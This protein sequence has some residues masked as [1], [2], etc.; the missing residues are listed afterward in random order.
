MAGLNSS[1]PDHRCPPLPTRAADEHAKHT[2]KE[3]RQEVVLYDHPALNPIYRY[4]LQPGEVA[5]SVKPVHLA[6][7][8]T[9]TSPGAVP[10]GSVQPLVAV[11]TGQGFG[12]DSKCMGRVLLFRVQKQ[13]EPAEGESQWGV[14]LVAAKDCASAGG[15]PGCYCSC[16]CKAMRFPAKC[17]H[18]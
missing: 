9:D 7:S 16:Q 11:T 14:T 8:G 3:E 12:E 10:A 4:T 17:T 5:T 18:S 1:R 6:S 15:W 2:G 13:E